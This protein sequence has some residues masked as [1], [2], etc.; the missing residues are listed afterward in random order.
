M[1]DMMNKLE[2]T[3]K[4]HYFLGKYTLSKLVQEE[5]ENLN[6]QAQMVLQVLSFK[7]SW[8]R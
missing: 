2:N 8:N 1:V 5:T 4:V 6:L 7:P 3:G